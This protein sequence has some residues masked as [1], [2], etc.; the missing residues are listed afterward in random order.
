MNRHLIE[1]TMVKVMMC[2]GM[3][4]VYVYVYWYLK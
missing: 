3:C 2:I 4:N 1:M